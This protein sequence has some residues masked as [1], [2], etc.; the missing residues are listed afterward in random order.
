MLFS[1]FISLLEIYY[2]PEILGRLSTGLEKTQQLETTKTPN[3]THKQNPTNQPHKNTLVCN[4]LEV[5]LG[6]LKPSAFL[7]APTQAVHKINT[8][9]SQQPKSVRTQAKSVMFSRVF[10]KFKLFPTQC[11]Q[12]QPEHSAVQIAS[13]WARTPVHQTM[14]TTHSSSRS[15]ADNAGFL[16]PSRRTS[17]QRIII[18]FRTTFPTKQSFKTFLLL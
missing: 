17:Q 11:F 15:A 18:F 2:I 7:S 6:Q 12:H 14:T 4:V 16:L 8:P 1:A 9:P 5:W 10:Q 13:L 3:Q